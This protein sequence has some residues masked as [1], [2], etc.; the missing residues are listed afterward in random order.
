MPVISIGKTTGTDAKLI[1]P[2]A[3]QINKMTGCCL[4]KQNQQAWQIE[5]AVRRPEMDRTVLNDQ[6]NQLR[7]HVKAFFL[8]KD[9]DLHNIDQGQDKADAITDILE[10]RYGF[11]RDEAHDQLDKFILKHGAGKRSKV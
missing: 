7:G 11:T 8:M 10:N 3:H 6:W 9:D 5:S 1:T 2:S 4:L